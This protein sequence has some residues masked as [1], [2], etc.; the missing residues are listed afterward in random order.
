MD[1]SLL[2]D[3]YPRRFVIHIK[4]LHNKCGIDERTFSDKVYNQVLKFR[5]IKS[6]LKHFMWIVKCILYKV[7]E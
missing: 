3:A 4:Y 7:H 6:I 5:E 1:F 2:A